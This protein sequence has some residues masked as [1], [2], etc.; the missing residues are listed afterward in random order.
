MSISILSARDTAALENVS[1]ADGKKLE[2]LMN[3]AVQGCSEFIAKRYSKSIY[4]SAA[5]LVG[6][7]HNGGDA[8]GIGCA[9]LQEGRNVAAVLAAAPETLKPLTAAMLNR[10]LS[11]G[12]Q[13]IALQANS[14]VHKLEINPLVA[15][16]CFWID[17]LFGFGLNRKV[18]GIAAQLIEFVNHQKKKIVSIDIPSGLSCDHGSLGGE[19]IQATDTLALGVLKPAHTD[20]TVLAA[21]GH[22]HCIPLP[23]AKERERLNAPHWDAVHRADLIELLAQAKRPSASHKVSNGRVLVV[24]GSKRYLG[25]GVLACL[26]AGVSSAGMIHALVPQSCQSALLTLMPEIIFEKRLPALENFTAIV[27][28]CGWVPGDAVLFEK[29]VAHSLR[30]SRTRLVLDAGAFGFVQRWLDSGKTLSDNIVLTPHLGEFGRLFPEAAKRLT[31]ASFEQ[32]LNRFEA[33]AWAADLSGAVILFKGARSHIAHPKG[34]VTSIMDSSPLLAHAGHGDVL[35]GFI[36]GL[37]ASGLECK[38]AALLAA[39]LQSQTA[40]C[41]SDRHPAALTLPPSELVRQMQFLLHPEKM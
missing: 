29:I 23:F 40:I 7:G 21:L 32:R 8:L 4:P 34:E 11:S 36:A 17:G 19:S 13:L 27:L 2:E 35:A 20:D 3:E 26:G 10:F 41:F 1:L 6:A 39:L 18:Q 15:D 24:A 28:G 25:A 9:L 12:G 30:H 31:A 38:K 33:A 37:A 5:L 16:A 22:V 14:D